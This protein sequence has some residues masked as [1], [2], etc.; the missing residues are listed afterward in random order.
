LTDL[1]DPFDLTH[2]IWKNESAFRDQVKA[3]VMKKLRKNPIPR[4]QG[5]IVTCIKNG[6]YLEKEVGFTDPSPIKRVLDA[7]EGVKIQN[8]TKDTPKPASLDFKAIVERFEEPYNNLSIPESWG[9]SKSVVITNYMDVYGETTVK[10]AVEE[11]KKEKD[12]GRFRERL[13]ESCK[14]IVHKIPRE[15]KKIVHPPV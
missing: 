13:S 3:Y 7:N 14:K 1:K 8:T 2:P 4:M 10:N 12:F 11:I 5:Y 15:C 6:W 9:L